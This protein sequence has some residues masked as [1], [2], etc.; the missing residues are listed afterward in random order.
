V[1]GLARIMLA[2]Q[3]RNGHGIEQP[4][5]SNGRRRKQI[6]AEVTRACS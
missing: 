3:Q 1:V 4:S 2:Q 5:P 6:V